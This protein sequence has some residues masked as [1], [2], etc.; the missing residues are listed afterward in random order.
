MSVNQPGAYWLAGAEGLLAGRPGDP[1]RNLWG[2][3]YL[4]SSILRLGSAIIVGT[5]GGLWEIPPDGGR[6]RQLHDETVTEVLDVCELPGG[7]LCVAFPYGVATADPGDLG[8][9]RWICRSEGLEVNERFSSRLLAPLS[10]SGPLLVGTEAGVLSLSTDGWEW[11][12][13]SL[14][15]SPCRALARWRGRLWAGTDSRG[16]WSSEDGE[17]W[18]QAGLGGGR[19]AVFCLAPQGELLLAG[20]SAGLTVTDGTGEWRRVGPRLR[21][22]GVAAAGETIVLGASPGGLWH[23]VDGGVRWNA[24]PGCSMV[25]AISAPEE[26]A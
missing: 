6:W 3:P 7:P 8:T 18:V 1:W 15:G 19:D 5:N 26:A 24:S 4:V 11:R 21:V 17:S 13:S 2:Y 14:M 16:I 9:L 25:R 10:S 20:T 22:T 12:R 23:S